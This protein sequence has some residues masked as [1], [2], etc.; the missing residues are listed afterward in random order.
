[1]RYAHAA[2]AFAGQWPAGHQAT[3]GLEAEHAAAGGGHA[4]GAAAIVAV[5][6]GNHSG[7]HQCRRA[8]AGAPG[9]V[10]EV[11][12][13]AGGAEA[14]R[15]GAVGSPELGGGAGT[16]EYAAGPAQA[17]NRFVVYP[18]ARFPQGQRAIGHA[19][20]GQR[21]EQVLH[22]GGNAGKRPIG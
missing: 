16:D 9:A 12:G 18:R 6:E 7:G 4:Q 8:A 2:P 10:F 20:L 22:Q 1:M 17:A 15:F 13:I 21:R 3:A 11:P 19:R 14:G 5:G